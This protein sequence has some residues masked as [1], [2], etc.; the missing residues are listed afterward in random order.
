MPATFQ[1][2]FAVLLLG[3]PMLPDSGLDGVENEPLRLPRTILFVD[4]ED[5]L[6]RPGT[7]KTRA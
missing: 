7:I 2:L 3:L 6:F 1:A 4:D 5:V